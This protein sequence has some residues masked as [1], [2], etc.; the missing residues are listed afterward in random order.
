[1]ARHLARSLVTAALG[2]AAAAVLAGACNP[3]LYDDYTLGA[4]GSSPGS[5]GTTGVASCG[6]FSSD[7]ATCQSCFVDSYCCTQASSCN[8]DCKS[9][10]SCLNGCLADE[11]PCRAGC[12]ESFSSGRTAVQSLL[13][14]LGRECQCDGLRSADGPIGSAQGAGGAGGSGPGLACQGEGACATLAY[15]KDCD[16]A[17]EGSCETDTRASRQHCGACGHDCLFSSC[18][19]NRCQPVSATNNVRLAKR[20]VAGGGYL[21]WVTTKSQV[22]SLS[23]DIISRVKIDGN[24][25]EEAAYDSGSEL[26]IY[27][28]T[29]DET[30]F[31]FVTDKG[32]LGREHESQ[33]A[34]RT[35]VLTTNTG[36]GETDAPE[37]V[38]IAT[39]T[40]SVFFTAPPT[41]SASGSQLWGA[42]K[43]GTGAVVST[44]IATFTS[45]IISG[46][47]A[48]EQT[49]Y[50]GS[51]DSNDPGISEATL[52]AGPAQNVYPG[53]TKSFAVGPVDFLV[54]AYDSNASRYRLIATPKVG[55]PEKVLAPGLYSSSFRSLAADATDFYFLMQESSGSAFSLARA[56][57]GDGASEVGDPFV[58]AAD[59]DRVYTNV[60]LALDGTSVFWASEYDT[61]IKRVA[62]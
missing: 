44:T 56:R 8:E 15:C 1:M 47:V 11:A 60:S 17:G 22:T 50:V 45:N 5:G 37:R 33:A 59:I 27:D 28:V 16:E 35:I 29:A 6:G 36:L 26:T 41:P 23:G 30:G 25:Q 55:G 10:I 53:R 40:T 52:P 20:L 51:D 42:P 2:A 43:A 49:V 34:T 58:L 61:T 46:L 3:S 9:Y 39:N 32:V 57:R 7:D 14:C 13:E 24:G 62:K 54:A 31:Y 21:Y 19:N 4:S 38:R 12:D 18:V 48:D